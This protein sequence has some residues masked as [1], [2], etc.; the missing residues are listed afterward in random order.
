M[1]PHSKGRVLLVGEQAD[2]ERLTSAG[3]D[4][5]WAPVEREALERASNEAFDVIVVDLDLPKLDGVSFVRRLLKS[6]LAASVVWV[7]SERS[8][9]L[10]AKAAEAGVLQV[11]Q[12]PVEA[13]A[14]ERVV[15][16][17]VEKSRQLL[18]TLRFILRPSSAHHSVAATEAKNEFGS[19]LETAIR[20]GAVVITKHESPRAVLVSVDRV[21]AVLDKYEPDLAA[22][23]RKFDAQVARMRTPEAR[24]AARGL[25][26]AT[27]EQ[28]GEAAVTGAKKNGG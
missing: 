23:T 4:A 14:L 21:G 8:N 3:F 19:V 24:A 9:E 10:A 26:A 2:S 5:Q 1:E 25:F 13:E 16:A 22:L 15:A 20:D 27:S 28:L 12:K 7:S 17:G 6:G 11:L 18:S